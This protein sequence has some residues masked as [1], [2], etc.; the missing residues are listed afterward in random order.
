M[1]PDEADFRFN[2]VTA[3]FIFL[4]FSIALAVDDLGIVIALVGATGS[5]IITYVLPGSVYWKIYEDNGLT[6]KRIAAGGLFVLGCL[7]MPVCV[8]F[9]FL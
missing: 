8:T 6:W 9:I 5:T 4:S 1:H 7:I 2:I 3:G